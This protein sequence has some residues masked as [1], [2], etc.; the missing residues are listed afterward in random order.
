MHNSLGSGQFTVDQFKKIGS[1]V[2]IEAGAL[3]FH[4][5]NIEI[6]DDVYI[7]HSTILKG[8][9]DKPMSIGSGTWIGPNCFLHSAGGLTIGTNVGIGPGVQVVTSSRAEEG[10]TKPILHGSLLFAP[11]EIERDAFVGIGAI[12][13]PGVRIGV[14]AH[15]GAGAV[16]T[17]RIPE[18]KVA[19]GSPARIRRDRRGVSAAP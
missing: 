12:V 7:G 19:V 6:G 10:P 3:V 11:V 14:G 18:Y 9:P 5:E 1:N 16:V 15:I 13:M 2:V 17:R 8:S 4:P